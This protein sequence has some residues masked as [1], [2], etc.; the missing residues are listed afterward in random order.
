MTTAEPTMHTRDLV[1][2]YALDPG[3]I[4]NPPRA[5]KGRLRFDPRTKDGKGFT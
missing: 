1:D 2:P 3:D 4:Q 5:L